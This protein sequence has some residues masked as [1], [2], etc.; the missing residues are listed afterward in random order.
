M[1]HVIQLTLTISFLT[2]SPLSAQELPRFEWQA[3]HFRDAGLTLSGRSSL[4]DT[5]PAGEPPAFEDWPVGARMAIGAVLGA[6]LGGAAGAIVVGFGQI[7]GPCPDAGPCEG[8]FQDFGKAM[9][10]GVG[11]GA[12]VGFV[13]GAVVA[14]VMATRETGGGRRRP[15]PRRRSNLTVG[16][17]HDG[18]FGLGA[19]VRF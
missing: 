3:A 11:I 16:P 10:I 1:R 2:V 19:S 4:L 6:A 13:V 7:L 5:H 14:G 12:G 18:K 8:N 15:Q 9:R 17:L